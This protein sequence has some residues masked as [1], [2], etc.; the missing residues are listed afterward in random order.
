MARKCAGTPPRPAI[1]AY[2]TT[3]MKP[4]LA[5]PGCGHNIVERLIAKDQTFHRTLLLRMCPHC[6]SQPNA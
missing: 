6:D 5:L 2:G 4:S 1:H 3:V